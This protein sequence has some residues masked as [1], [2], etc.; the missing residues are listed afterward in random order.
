MRKQFITEVKRF[1]HKKENLALITMAVVLCTGLVLTNA[2]NHIPLHDGD[3]LVDSQT[4][5]EPA[6]QEEEAVSAAASSLE[7]KRATLDLERNQLIASFDETIKNTASD[8]EKKNAIKQKEQLTN[9]MSQ[10]IAIEGIL[11]TKN[12]PDSLVIITENTVNVTV[13][14][15]DLQQNTVT[16]ICNVVMAETGRTAD[17]IIIQS[18]Y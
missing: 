7:E 13:D 8:A 1:L 10:E 17:K 2:K 3:V 12:L 14:E 18:L 6:Q 5:S 11:D 16:K 9:Y 4:L 15:Q